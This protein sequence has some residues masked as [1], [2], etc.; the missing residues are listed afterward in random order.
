MQLMG[1]LASL[2]LVGEVRQ[3]LGLQIG[4]KRDV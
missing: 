1:W 2:T 3:N 4:R